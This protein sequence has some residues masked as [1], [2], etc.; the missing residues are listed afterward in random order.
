MA[1]NFFSSDIKRYDE[2]CKR[3]GRQLMHM[4]PLPVTTFRNSLLS[5]L[6]DLSKLFY[7][8]NEKKLFDTR[9]VRIFICEHK[10]ESIDRFY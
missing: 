7:I 3:I 10:L 5:P 2:A 6:I 4:T 8:C 1:N 9:N